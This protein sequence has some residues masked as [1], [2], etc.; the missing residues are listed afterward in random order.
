MVVVLEALCLDR[1][2]INGRNQLREKGSLISPAVDHTAVES[3]IQSMA[4]LLQQKLLP[5]LRTRRAEPLPIHQNRRL[6]RGMLAR[7]GTLQT[8]QRLTINQ[9][10]PQ[11]RQA[12]TACQ[13][14]QYATELRIPRFACLG[15]TKGL[16]SQTLEIR[17]P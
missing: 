2:R 8:L 6:P 15:R 1:L 4:D 5:F 11:S 13:H 10:K 9:L 14:S 12:F 3:L 16:P 7:I 17:T